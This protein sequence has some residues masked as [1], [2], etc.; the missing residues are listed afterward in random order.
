MDAFHREGEPARAAGT[1]RVRDS[2]EPGSTGAWNLIPD[3]P[4]N[5]ARG[6]AQGGAL[7]G[8]PADLHH[9][10][11]D[12]PPGEM[13]LE[14]AYAAVHVEQAPQSASLPGGGAA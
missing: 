7:V 1:I 9:T 4:L 11:Q 2:T 8:G 14:P 10:G 12:R 5:C 6:E 13:A 3:R